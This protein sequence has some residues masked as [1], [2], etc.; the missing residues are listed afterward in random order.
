MENN[1]E[2]GLGFWPG[3]ALSRRDALFIG[4]IR[5]SRYYKEFLRRG[6]PSGFGG[7]RV[8]PF[9]GFGEAGQS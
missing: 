1:L 6:L 7:I 2:V 3:L 9:G 8:N 5:Y 4:L